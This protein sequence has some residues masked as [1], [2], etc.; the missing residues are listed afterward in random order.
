MNYKFCMFILSHG[1]AD[2]I[3][4]LNSLKRSGYT[5]DYYI[6]IDNEDKTADEYYKRFGDRVI[7]FDKKAI[8]KTFDTADNFDDRKT[9]VFARNAC[10]EIAERIGYTHFMELDDD[11]TRFSFRLNKDGVL[12]DIEIRNLDYI[13][14][15]MIEY[16]EKSG[17]TC[18]AFAQNGDFIGGT[19]GMGKDIHIKRKAMNTLLCSTKRPFK[20]LGRINEDVNT[21]VRLGQVGKLFMTIN[22]ISIKQM[23][24]Q[25]NEGGMT[26]IYLENGTYIKSFYSVIYS[27]SSV[28]ISR[29]GN[30][31]RRIHH[32]IRWRNTTP[33]VIDEKFRK[34]EGGREHVKEWTTNEVD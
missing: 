8:S 15:R 12:K 20:F 2:R 14:E 30:K 24:T 18:L 27:P 7:M 31:H 9:I 21:Y 5:G 33:Y 32:K 1:R 16:Y 26:D 23:Q 34:I 10:F 25:T 29:M 17:A 3:H 11:Y 19:A 28:K 22:L 13:M 6:V 4:T